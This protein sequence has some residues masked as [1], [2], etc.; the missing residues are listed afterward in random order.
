MSGCHRTVKEGAA[1]PRRGRMRSRPHN[2]DFMSFKPL[3]APTAICPGLASSHGTRRTVTQSFPVLAAR[4]FLR[5]RAMRHAIP[6][7][8]AATRPSSE[9]PAVDWPEASQSDAAH[10]RTAG[11]EE[12]WCELKNQR[13]DNGFAGWR[14]RHSISLLQTANSLPGNDDRQKSAVTPR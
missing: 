4:F 3:S 10:G 6:K 7:N 8:D 1:S 12:G 9:A 11:G 2:T 13:H 14:T 5:P